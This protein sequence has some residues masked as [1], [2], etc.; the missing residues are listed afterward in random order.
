M[1]IVAATI[2]ASL[3]LQ[4]LPIAG[5]STIRGRV[6]DPDGRPMAGVEMA[7]MLAGSE[8]QV[9]GVSGMTDDEGRFSIT[10]VPASRI[11]LRAL[12]RVRRQVAPGL[13][14]RVPAH[15]PAYFPGVLTLLDAWP[16]EV[17]AEEIIEL[18]F[19][20]PPVL[21]GSI[22]ATV[23]GP[24]DYTL[25]QFR[26]IRP[27]ANEI[28]NVTVT[29][30]S[31]YVDDLREG[32]YVVVARGHAKDARLAAWEIVHMTAGELAVDLALTPA[33]TISGRVVAD[34]GGIPPIAGMR[35]T[36][37]WTDG[38]IDL[39]P[40]TRDQADVA[41]DG[42][43]T[44]NGLFGTRAI[45][46]TGLTDGWEVASI[47]HGRTDVTTSAVDLSAGTTSEITIVVSR[48]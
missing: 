5:R 22:K 15:P 8:R 3:L 42:S 30:G 4:L 21:V 2:T 48:K 32:R 38:T 11:I 18:D 43:F 17:G 6:I 33:A 31:G 20:M 44:I 47:R 13:A 28:K 27:E 29:D 7:A 26:V 37:A 12:P 41:P 40:L 24:D 35:V 19:Y 1:N 9:V 16:I 23:T 45:R 14:T 10:K 46:V 39:D 25:E 36:A 34:R